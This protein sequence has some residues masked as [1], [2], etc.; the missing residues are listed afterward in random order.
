[1]CSDVRIYPAAAVSDLT[2]TFILDH[3]Y[4]NYLRYQ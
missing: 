4:L 3:H 1:M 2:L